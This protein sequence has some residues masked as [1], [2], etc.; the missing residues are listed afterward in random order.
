MRSALSPSPS[1]PA[2]APA[3]TMRPSFTTA[4]NL[5][6]PVILLGWRAE[7][8]PSRDPHV[9]RNDD[10]ANERISPFTKACAVVDYSC[11]AVTAG[12]LTTKFRTNLHRGAVRSSIGGEANPCTAK[13]PAVAAD[14]VDRP[15]HPFGWRAEPFRGRSGKLTAAP[16][17]QRRP[18]LPGKTRG[19]PRQT[20]ATRKTQLATPL[21][22]NITMNSS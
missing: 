18:R 16:G 8:F 11:A 4:V 9:T 14:T 2:V 1:S 13:A 17:G 22:S 5:D 10:P 6:R 12:G 19:I 21:H 7:R 3:R 15:R 20:K